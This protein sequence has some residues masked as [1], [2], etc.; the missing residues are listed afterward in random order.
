MISPLFVANLIVNFVKVKRG[1][2]AEKFTIKFTTK[3]F[4]ALRNVQIR[5]TIARVLSFPALFVAL[6]F[7]SGFNARAVLRSLDP[8]QYHLRSGSEPEWQ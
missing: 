3:V 1:P 2:H 4:L 8:N 6:S 5:A 7:L